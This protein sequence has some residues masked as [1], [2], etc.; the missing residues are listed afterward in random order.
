MRFSRKG[1]E[2]QREERLTGTVRPTSVRVSDVMGRAAHRDGSPYLGAGII[3]VW[4]RKEEGR[5]QDD[6]ATM[7]RHVVGRDERPRSSASD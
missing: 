3:D 4:E 5:E 1:S 2:T 7:G 6:P